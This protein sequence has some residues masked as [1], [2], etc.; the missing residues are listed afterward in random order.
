MELGNYLLLLAS[1]LDSKSSE[2]RAW[3]EHRALR[4]QSALGRQPREAGEGAALGEGREGGRPHRPSRRVTLR[5]SCSCLSTACTSSCNSQRNSSSC[6]DRPV[7]SRPGPPPPAPPR[8]RASPAPPA[9]PPSL[10]SRSPS[11]PLAAQRPSPARRP[12]AAQSSVAPGPTPRRRLAAR[13][14]APPPARDVVS[15][16]ETACSGSPGIPPAPT[17]GAEH[18]G[19]V[20]IATVGPERRGRSSRPF[21]AL[22][23]RPAPRTLTDWP[24][25]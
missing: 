13:A 21:S 3:S 1:R 7:V 9:P 19:A 17:T 20:S 23:G 5:M 24:A 6:G 12:L 16:P 4:T 18:S 8:P 2:G 25:R 10:P 11:P 14:P 15:A 22:I